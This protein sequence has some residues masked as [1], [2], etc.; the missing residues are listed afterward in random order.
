MPIS[1]DVMIEEKSSDGS[2]DID[3]P[4]Q[5]KPPLLK[6]LPR[7][8]DR[9]TPVKKTTT[10]GKTLH[11]PQINV[12]GVSSEKEAP[13]TDRTFQSKRSQPPA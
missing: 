12:F 3:S 2:D 6:G 4:E 8:P 7:T 5:T 10:A 1:L 9:T 11:T 13:L